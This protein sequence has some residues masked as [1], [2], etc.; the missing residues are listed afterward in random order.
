MISK[1]TFSKSLVKNKKYQ[2]TFF[3]KNKINK[4]NFGDKR[5]QQYKDKTPI[6]L[7]SNLDHLNVKRRFFI[8]KKSWRYT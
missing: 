2:V 5:Y 7:Y 3:Y 1:V 4:V 8:F 6:K